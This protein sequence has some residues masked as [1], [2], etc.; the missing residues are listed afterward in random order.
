MAIHDEPTG[1]PEWLG[2]NLLDSALANHLGNVAESRASLL[3]RPWHKLIAR[4]DTDKDAID[5]FPN[6]GESFEPS[7]KA[8]TFLLH[9]KDEIVEHKGRTALVTGAAILAC[10]KAIHLANK[11]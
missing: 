8:G 10:A 4:M 2:P 9:F 1:S 5:F 11:K 6:N 3:K 7:D